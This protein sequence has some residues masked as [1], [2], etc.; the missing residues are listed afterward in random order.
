MPSNVETEIK[1]AVRSAAHARRLLRAAGFRQIHRRAFESNQLYD[2]PDNGLRR[3]GCMIRVRTWGTEA[4]VTFKGPSGRSTRYKSRE[5]I[6]TPVA[7]AA[8]M[9]EILELLGLVPG[10]RY[11]KFRAVFAQPGQ[12][13]VAAVDE[14]PIGVYLELEGEADWI[15]RIAARMGFSPGAYRLESYATIYMEDCLR[16]G[17]EAGSMVFS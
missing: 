16:R 1:L 9:G 17:V 15:D 3:A 2:W 6:E 14:T 4:S 13:G 12:P 11:E 7:D 8:Q 10:Y 5:E